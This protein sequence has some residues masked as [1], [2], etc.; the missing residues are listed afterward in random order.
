[1]RDAVSSSRLL[2]WIQELSLLRQPLTNRIN[3]AFL[4]NAPTFAVFLDIAG[5]FDNV[6]LQILIRDLRRVGFPVLFCKFVQNL[7]FERSILA[8]QNGKLLGPLITHKGTLQDSILS[9]LL[10]NFYLRAIAHEMHSI[11]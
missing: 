2:V 8:V 6:I 11:A 4:N 1:L 7:L 9:P 3:S 10:F 5:A